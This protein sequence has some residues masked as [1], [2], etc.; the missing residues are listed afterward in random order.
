MK[1]PTILVGEDGIEYV[2]RG[3]KI[4][5]RCLHKTRRDESAGK[6]RKEVCHDCGKI[7]IFNADTTRKGEYE[8][9]CDSFRSFHGRNPR[10]EELAAML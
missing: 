4:Q 6:M 5:E 2:I 10:G 3:G 8:S 7:L 1:E 9:F